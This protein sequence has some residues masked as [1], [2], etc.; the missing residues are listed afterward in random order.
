M[1]VRAI[2]A[3]HGY[4]MLGGRVNRHTGSI[5]L[6]ML[7]INGGVGF[8]Y[9]KSRNK[10]ARKANIIIGLLIV[11]AFALHYLNPWLLS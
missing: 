8:Y 7:V 6:L 1:T 9:K 3:L 4:I 2:G 11:L 5:L 10:A